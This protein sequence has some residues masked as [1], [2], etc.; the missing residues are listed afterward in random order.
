MEKRNSFFFLSTFSIIHIHRHSI[1]VNILVVKYSFL[2]A[3]FGGF[4][5]LS[6][7]SD[8]PFF[9]VVLIVIDQTSVVFHFS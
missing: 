3:H 2:V 5:C 8:F 7:Y 9:V 6:L 1:K 4:V